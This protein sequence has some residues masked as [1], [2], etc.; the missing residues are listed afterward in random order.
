MK[1]AKIL[2][3]AFA[4]IL[5]GASA[6][7]A[8]VQFTTTS[9]LNPIA[10]NA[11]T[12]LAG[13]I[14]LTQLSG[15]NVGGAALG[16]ETLTITYGGAQISEFTTIA[17]TFT[18]GGAPVSVGLGG[19]AAFAAYGTAVGTTAA[20]GGETVG[21]LKVTI[22]TTN[23]AIT[24]PSA[25]APVA[26]VAG[27][28]IQITGVRLNVVPVTSGTTL[29]GTLSAAL[30]SVSGQITVTNP[31]LLI[32]LISD[33]FTLTGPATLASIT[34]GGVNSPATASVTIQELG[35]FTNAFETQAAAGGD[36]DATQIILTISNI[37]AGITLTAAANDAA[38]TSGTV[39][40]VPAA[41]TQVGSTATVIVGIGAQS[42]TTAEKIG[43][44]LTF[45]TTSTTTYPI[46]LGTATCTAT[47]GREWTSTE[48]GTIKAGGTGLNFD[49]AVGAKNVGDLYFANLKGP[50]NV[51]TITQQVTE[52][53]S[54]FNSY[55]PPTGT[56][57]TSGYLAGF[58]TGFDIINTTGVL[59]V[60]AQADVITVTFY[61]ADGSTIT[62]FTTSATNR[63]GS[64]LNA[65][66]QLP[67]GAS[68]IV[69]LSDLLKTAGLTGSWNGG[70]IRFTCN[71]IFAHGINYI[72]D[73]NFAVS[74]QGYEMLVITGR[75][76]SPN[77]ETNGG[78]GH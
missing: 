33:P 66:G 63:P 38:I 53:L 32:A 31:N 37:P 75:T 18:N 57:G 23:I 64:G 14:T 21:A 20:V 22:N 62:A 15:T 47:L 10:P 45:A 76:T 61:S 48:A 5:I 8:T 39:T 6:S 74:A 50:V 70:F 42:N 34:T 12:G 7:Y 27:A 44:A 17:V 28:T 35:A 72:S 2:V 60:N 77:L 49:T 26:F 56:P 11:R 65:N 73:G 25:G 3:V 16:G 29:G 41:P 51:F 40:I 71:F 52:L 9:N 46:P 54:V 43:V 19:G 13:N 69:L 58:N 67:A 36:A 55:I 30:N 4:L 68:W 24:F 78:V 1:F 59:K